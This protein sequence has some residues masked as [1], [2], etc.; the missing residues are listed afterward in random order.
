[1]AM[2]FLQHGCTREPV[3][4][5]IL[6]A[7]SLV[8]PFAEVE[9]EFEK[10]HPDIDV[11]LEGHGSIQVIRHITEIH[12]EV[13]IA[14]VADYSLIPMLLYPAQLPGNQG[15]YADWTIN[16]ATNRL[17]LAYTPQSAYSDEI[18]SEN[19]YEILSRDDV[20]FGF[21]DPRF[22]AC[23]YRSLMLIK[24]AE[25]YYDDQDI[26][27]RL[28]AYNFQ[29][30]IKASEENGVYAIQI[31]ESFE[32]TAERVTLRGFSVQLLALLES[33]DLDYA[34]Q[35]ES[36][37]KQHGLE[38]LGLPAQIDLSTEEYF[39][40]YQKVRVKIDFRRFA[41]VTPEFQGQPIV[42]GITIPRNAP[43]KEEAL[44]F[45]KFLLSSEGQQI[46]RNTSQPVMRPTVDN[47]ENLLQE[48]RALVE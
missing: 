9:K 19:W 10:R 35:Y 32:P 36:V 29:P 34:F 13:D 28:V 15:P 2:V 47:T 7:G 44:E 8:I 40:D 20:T 37:A 22:D 11:L 31:P 33:R 25:D 38:F 5:H 27:K 39:G 14:A 23:G 4:L 6:E 1:M 17:G 43:H 18:N 21:S 45:L 41:T 12:D 16:F 26:F 48:L 3:Q 46:L 42:Y 30:R 24:L